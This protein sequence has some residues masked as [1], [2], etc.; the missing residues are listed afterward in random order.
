M[1][2][3]A[4]GSGW[5]V[6]PRAGPAG[7]AAPD[8]FIIRMTPIWPDAGSGTGILNVVGPAKA[9]F[10]SPSSPTFST[11][12]CSVNFALGAIGAFDGSCATS[13][14]RYASAVFSRHARSH[15]AP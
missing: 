6:F 8:A 4:L 5:G 7:K 1:S 2:A 11:F 9:L 15:A 14:A 10:Q 13:A 3:G 12:D